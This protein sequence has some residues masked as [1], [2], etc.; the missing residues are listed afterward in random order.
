MKVL[1][2]AEMFF[3]FLPISQ[4]SI[5]STV[6]SAQTAHNGVNA[7]SSYLFGFPH[8]TFNHCPGLLVAANKIHNAFCVRC[9]PLLKNA[10]VP[11]N[12]N[13]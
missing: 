10:E 4:K 13:H 2:T 3:F 11:V 6:G 5:S 7:Y 9:T 8:Q 12:N 1:K